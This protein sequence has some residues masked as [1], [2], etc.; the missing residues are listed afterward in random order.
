LHFL[1]VSIEDLPK[2]DELIV[3][4]DHALDALMHLGGGSDGYISS[5]ASNV[6]P[7]PLFRHEFVKDP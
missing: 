6:D 7:S 5:V 4:P 3:T 1:K 2:V